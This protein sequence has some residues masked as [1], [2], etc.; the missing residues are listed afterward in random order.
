M[1]SKKNPNVGGD[2]TLRRC[3]CH[4]MDDVRPQFSSWHDL[5]TNAGLDPQN[6]P[7]VLA[8]SGGVDS[9][10]VAHILRQF[11]AQ[12]P[13]KKQSLRALIIDHGIRANSAQEAALTAHRLNALGIPNRIERL[14]TPAPEKGIQAWAR[15]HRYQ[16][17]W[18]EACRDQAAIVTGHHRE[19]Q[20]ET[21]MMRLSKGSGIKGLAGM[22]TQSDRHGIKMIR[23][24][25]TISKKAL[26]DYVDQHGIEYVDDPSNDNPKFE[27]VRW[28][29][30]QPFYNGMG[31]SANNLSRLAKLFAALDSTMYNQVQGLKGR[32]FGL[33]PWGQ[34]WIAH[35]E[36]Q[37]LPD[38]IQRQ[39]LA[40]ILQQVAGSIHPPSQDALTR[41]HAWFGVLSSKARTLGGVEFTPKINRAG[42]QL[43]WVYP[44]AERPWPAMDCSEGHH[45]IDGRWHL[46]LPQSA[47]IRPLGES[48]FAKVKKNL[49]QASQNDYSGL[50]VCLDAP[51]RSFW[52]LPMVDNQVNTPN[53]LAQNPLIALE[54]GCMIPH[55]INIENNFIEQLMNANTF[56]MRFSGLE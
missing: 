46:Y 28:R 50:Q 49:K 20:A 33:T 13:G 11:W 14:T 39:V 23:P 34:G 5:C 48:G 26:R 18:R 51:A 10:A 36:W 54:D 44:E 21:M 29:Q 38:V 12:H 35:A 17:L 19:D 9:M 27:R 1:G 25:L 32:V 37:G 4:A 31:F 16:A 47:R 7:V 24:F 40:Q 53:F 43:V 30:A 3:F 52:R 42:R 55:V 2:L 56:W 15:D 8:V 45:V 22:R 41:L 6:Q